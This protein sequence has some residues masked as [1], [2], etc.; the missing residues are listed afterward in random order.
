MLDCRA[1][2]ARPN[3]AAAQRRDD[4]TKLNATA[5]RDMR[6]SRITIPVLNHQ[7]KI[8][9]PRAMTASFILGFQ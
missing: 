2:C 9:N 5:E 8:A 7:I 3:R 6:L 1:V 4:R